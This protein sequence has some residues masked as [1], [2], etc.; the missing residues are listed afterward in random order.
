[1]L[2]LKHTVCLGMRAHTYNF[3]TWKV[4]AGGLGL[5]VIIYYVL[6][7]AILSYRRTRLYK[8]NKKANKNKIPSP[9]SSTKTTLAV[10]EE[11]SIL[12]QF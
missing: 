1:M 8:Q 6:S 5:Q 9:G 10:F 11:W 7:E 3:N 4:G 2:A 12:S